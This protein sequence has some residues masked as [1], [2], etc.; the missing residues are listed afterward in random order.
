[1]RSGDLAP[2]GS[3]GGIVEVDETYVGGSKKFR[4]DN[5]HVKK[6]PMLTLVDRVTGRSASFVVKNANRAEILPILRANLDKEARVITDDSGVYREL[7]EE[8]SHA[9][10]VHSKGQYGR[11]EIHT[12]T[13]EGYYSVFKCGMKGVYQHCS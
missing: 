7:D 10:V 6:A 13:V 2:F 9:F 12:N 5:K 1:M 4:K 8:Y 3:G 11:G